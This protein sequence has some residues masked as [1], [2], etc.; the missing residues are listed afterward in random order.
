MSSSIFV[1]SVFLVLSLLLAIILY[2]FSQL[3]LQY[4]DKIHRSRE[5]KD[6]L[7]SY[8]IT[9]SLA[10]TWYSISIFFTMYNKLLMQMWWDGA[11]DFPLF[12]TSIHMIF[13]VVA[14]RI[15]KNLPSNKNIIIDASPIKL[16]FGI[17]I[18]TA[19]DVALSNESVTTLSIP[20]YTTLKA[21]SLCFTFLWGIMIGVENFKYETFLAVLLISGGL[22]IAVF[23]A[24]QFD[25]LGAILCL[26]ASSAA[27]LRWAL[28]Q[29]LIQSSHKEIKENVIISLYQ[30]APFTLCIIPFAI[31]IEGESIMSSKFNCFQIAIIFSIIGGFISFCL[32]V[33]EMELVKK[34]SSVTM[35][36]FGQMK[37][38]AQIS[39]SMF[40]FN[41][42]LTIRSTIGII[43][44]IAAAFYY[45]KLKINENVH[46]TTFTILKDEDFDIHLDDY[47]DSDE[48]D[49]NEFI[50]N[51]SSNI[52][53]LTISK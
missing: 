28:L 42:N 44:S 3:L 22:M 16:L 35:A 43:L 36:V 18:C 23:G 10:A 21:S 20:L 27:G 11:Y 34:T 52:K 19:I 4:D 53:M 39:L 32:I 13:K 15:Y 5:G 1:L 47:Y 49:D 50:G 51:S 37:E 30:F 38:V 6:L 2:I 7:Y 24:D 9:A 12:N 40:V 8:L 14:T 31:G 33:V 17:G 46:I 25:A 41:D 29:L 26:L 45:R 48:V